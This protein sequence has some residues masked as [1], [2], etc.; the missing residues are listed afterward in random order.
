MKYTHDI[1]VSTPT[2]EA[3]S[4]TAALKEVF[5]HIKILSEGKNRYIDAIE[6]LTAIED[7]TNDI[8]Y[9]AE[10]GLENLRYWTEEEKH[11]EHIDCLMMDEEPH[12]H[13]NED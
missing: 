5:N 11:R 12:N 13:T 3:L 1:T 6:L 4:Y 9:I 7:T 2:A 10:R 8:M